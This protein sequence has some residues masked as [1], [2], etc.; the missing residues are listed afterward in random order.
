MTI[1]F[2]DLAGENGRRFSPYC[3]RAH[4]ALAHKQLD[5]DIRETGFTDIKVICDGAQRSLPVID[6]KGMLVSDSFAIARYLEATYPDAPSLF[7][8]EAGE[9][10]ARFIEAWAN[11]Q[12]MPV[13]I[14]CCIKDIHDGL[15]ER[16]KTYFR[17]TRE[18]RFGAS[19]EAVQEG[20]EGR[21]E[22]LHAALTPLRVM[23]NTQPWIGGESPLYADYIVFGALQ[24]GR[25][26]S[27]M[28]LLKPDDPV[29]DWFARC[30]SLHGGIGAAMPAAA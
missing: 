16:D 13:I 4:M 17:E 26:V 14:R 28:P 2:Y 12:L 23:L 24:W 9:A 5:V 19:L 30:L 27:T 1:T 3:W 21:V 6:D 8:G 20:R 11:T 22:D 25:V 15:F 18:K 29:A 10:S 7:G